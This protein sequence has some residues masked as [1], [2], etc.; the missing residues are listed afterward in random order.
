MTVKLVTHTHTHTHFHI[1][2]GLPI[3]VMILYYTNCIFYP[4]TLTPNLPIKG[5]D[6]QF[7]K[8]SLN[9]IY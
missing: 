7:Q 6:L 1:S 4:L 3:Y 2:W 8:T 9:L 5:N